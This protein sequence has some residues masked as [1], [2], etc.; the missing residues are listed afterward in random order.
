MRRIDWSNQG[1]KR[2]GMSG[3]PLSE[4]FK[5]NYAYL[6]LSGGENRRMGGKNKLFLEI[7]GRRQ[8]ERLLSCIRETDEGSQVYLSVKQGENALEYE[9]CG[10][11]CIPDLVRGRGPVAGIASA[12]HHLNMQRTSFQEERGM[13]DALLILSSDLFGLE[14]GVLLPLL[15]VYRRTGNAVFYKGRDGLPLP[16]PGIYPL[17]MEGFLRQELS[18]GHYRLRGVLAEWAA[19]KKTELISPPE[20]FFR[21]KNLN[22][23]ED[24]VA[25][26][27]LKE[28]VTGN[29]EA[30]GEADSDC[31]GER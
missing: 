7:A 3:K 16:F 10:L 12:M 11:P 29:K 15:D 25:A 26:A 14:R 20:A 23:P 30:A 6:I 21:V 19:V 5:N 4:G 24:A 8:L 9:S 31:E 1:G 18:L 17:D 13:A 2:A 22:T 28:A 27:L